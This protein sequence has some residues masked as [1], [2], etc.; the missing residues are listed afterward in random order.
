MIEIAQNL[1]A[2]FNDPVALLTLDM[3]NETNAAGIMLATGVIEA[4]RLGCFAHRRALTWHVIL[5]DRR[6]PEI[7]AVQQ[8]LT[9]EPCSISRQTSI[10]HQFLAGCSRQALML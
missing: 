9:I 4:L 8:V 3:G 1:Q 6:G 5:H 7:V 2:L 10:R